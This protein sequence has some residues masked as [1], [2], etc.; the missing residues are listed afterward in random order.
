MTRSPREIDMSMPAWFKA[1]FVAAALL[2]LA[3]VGFGVWAVYTVVTAV[4]R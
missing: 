1:V 4:A 3:L 2:G